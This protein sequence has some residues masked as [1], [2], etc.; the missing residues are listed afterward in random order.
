MEG[1]DIH[2]TAN[3]AVQC[4]TYARL[5][6][7]TAMVLPDCCPLIVGVIAG[8]PAVSRGLGAWLQMTVAL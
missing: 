7:K 3:M 5:C 8:K 1:L 6:G 4:K 2:V